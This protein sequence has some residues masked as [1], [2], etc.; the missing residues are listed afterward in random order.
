MPDP[1]SE[2]SSDVAQAGSAARGRGLH[3]GHFWLGLAIFIGVALAYPF[4][5]FR[6]QQ[7]LSAQVTPPLVQDIPPQAGAMT[8]AMERQNQIAARDAA[9]KVVFPEPQAVL[10]MGTTM[11]GRA[12]VVMVELGESGLPDARDAI[13]RQAAEQFRESLAGMEL[14]V[15]RYEAGQAGV[16]IGKV[17]CD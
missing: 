13:C 7:H 4:Y 5:A 1:R 6:V 16:D 14:T 11:V 8:A 17:T 3:T 9:G 2:Q 15:Q 12:R 10:V